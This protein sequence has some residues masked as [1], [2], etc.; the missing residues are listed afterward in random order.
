MFPFI[1]YWGYKL[2]HIFLPGFLTLKSIIWNS[3]LCI[4]FL[5]VWII[6]SNVI[7]SWTK[8]RLGGNFEKNILFLSKKRSL[9]LLIT[10]IFIFNISSFFFTKS[11]DISDKQ[12]IILLI[13]ALRA[14][15]LGCYGYDRNTSPV[16]DQFA[17]DAVVFKQA[18]TQS[19]FTKTSIASVFTSKNP[20]NH[21][22]YLG[23]SKDTENK[24]TSDVL[25]KE[26]NTLAEILLKNGFITNAWIHNLHLSSFMG[27]SQGF[28]G[29]HEQL[30]SI[31]NIN[32]KYLDWMS[33]IGK[34]YRFFSYIHYID[35]HD[36]YKPKPPYDKMYGSYSD[37][38]SNIDCANWGVY[39]E[40]IR[41]GKITLSKKQVDQLKAYYDGLISYIDKQIG[42]LL[43]EL[44]EKGVYDNSLIIL[45]ADH[46][47]GF[48]E[49]KFISHSYKPYD[50]LLRVPLIVKFP[51]LKWR[52]NVI[53]KQVRLIDVMPMILDYM[54][55]EF[56]ENMD[57]FSLLNYLRNGS[58]NKKIDFPQYAITEIFEENSYPISSIRTENYKY[59]HYQ[60]KEDE[61]YN[62]KKDP[63]EKNN[64]ININSKLVE[65]FH[66]MQMDIVAQRSQRNA[67]KKVVLDKE[68][69]EELK[70][71][72]YIK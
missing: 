60:R 6:I 5:F 4:G 17:N 62:L 65:K 67:V 45:I 63:L 43:K 46:G 3:I 33:K 70:T 72:G 66:K 48:M 50:E 22:V 57:G 49:H 13:D 34:N 31:E 1:I 26:E 36:P 71:L 53:N 58:C 44:K 23:N 55:I 28:V 56:N 12:I 10:I 11:K 39:L 37:F 21:K 14:D 24:I 19:T 8:I 29:Y 47:D 16:I 51:R 38:Y 32:N 2:N 52:G 30:G 7:K 54:N 27:F 9:F 64:I 18:I 42:Y 61:F 40:D 59:I 41:K 35:L 15:H 25:S 69:V 20:Y 68:T